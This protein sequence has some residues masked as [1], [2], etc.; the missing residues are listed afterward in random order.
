[1]LVINDGFMDLLTTGR[2]ARG[3]RGRRERDRLAGGF[4]EGR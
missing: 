4:P 2:R 3:H 1:M